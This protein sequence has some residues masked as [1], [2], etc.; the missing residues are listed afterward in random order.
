[1]EKRFETALCRKSRRFF[2][3]T[4]IQDIWVNHTWLWGGEG[5]ACLQLKGRGERAEETGKGTNKDPQARLLPPPPTRVQAEPWGDC[6]HACQ[7]L[8]LPCPC[9][10]HPVALTAVRWDAGLSGSPFLPSM[11]EGR[12][13][14]KPPEGHVSREY[15][16]PPWGV[17]A[18]A[19]LASGTPY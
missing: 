10:L 12:G 19:G 15:R 18:S 9:K 16:A 8:F 3:F 13:S 6:A 5:E 17:L 14:W 2:F 4:N 7:R 11:W 1:M